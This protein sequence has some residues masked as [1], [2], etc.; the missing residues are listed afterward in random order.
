[1]TFETINNLWVGVAA[2]HAQ[3]NY[4]SIHELQLAKVPASRLVKN[5][6]FV[7]RGYRKSLS[8]CH[9]ARTLDDPKQQ[10]DQQHIFDPGNV[11]L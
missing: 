8:N 2:S 10:A 1:M 4:A 9:P 11:R 5:Y 3:K 6:N 7:L